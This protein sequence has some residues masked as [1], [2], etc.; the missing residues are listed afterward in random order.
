MNEIGK[1]LIIL[2]SLIIL[3]GLF[4]LLSDKLPY[5]GKLPGDI[6]VKKGNFVFYFPVVTCIVISIILTLILNLL[7]RK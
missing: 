6:Y 7:S 5:I 4:I 1:F 2:G 3:V